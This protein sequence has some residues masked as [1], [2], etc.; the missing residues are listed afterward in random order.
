MRIVLFDLSIDGHHLS[1]ASFLIQY[2][3]ERDHIV[4]FVTLKPDDRITHMTEKYPGLIVEYVGDDV[5]CIQRK[6]SVEGH[7][8]MLNGLRK[9]F[10]FADRFE[11]DAVHLL[12]MDAC[13]IPLYFLSRRL[14]RRSWRLFGLWF[15]LH[16]VHSAG[17]DATIKTRIY[18]KIRPFA[19][20]RVFEDNTLDVLFVHTEHIKQAFMHYYRWPE[21]F[22]ERIVVAPDPVEIPN[23]SCS[24]EEARRKIDLPI[25]IP[26]ILCFGGLRK[27]KGVDIL[28]E[29]VRNVNH[30]FALVVAGPA[31]YFTQSDVDRW[32]ENLN[33]TVQVID[34]IRFIQD[35]IS[36]YFMSA[37]V[38]VLP[39]RKSFKGTSNVL[40]RA[41]GARKP[42]I[43]H[44]VGELGRIVREFSLGVVVN[45]DSLTDLSQTIEY[46]LSNREQ[47]TERIMPNAIRYAE[48]HHWRVMTAN[49]E[50][51][52]LQ[53][54]NEQRR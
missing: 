31:G 7:L 35:E 39:H 45:P 26:I 22:E 11:A 42:V 41:V 25:G 36:Y 19:L 10:E 21:S 34:R 12:Y 16:F 1:Y 2:L 46:L 54:R 37:D 47:I 43:V 13:D 53:Y 38:V 5:R 40:Q 49:I 23:F 48:E 27:D 28:F 32:K 51:A 29:A 44:D 50:Q 3:L 17:D 4:A 33:E 9:C 24:Q 14:R 6:V 18:H 30:R 15:W 8:Q 52:Y 20:K